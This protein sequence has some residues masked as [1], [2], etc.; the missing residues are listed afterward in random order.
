MPELPV[1]PENDPSAAPTPLVPPGRY[2]P[3]RTRMSPGVLRLLVGVVA[4]VVLAAV[5]WMA[6]GQQ[7]NDVRGRDVGYSVK[8]PEVVEITFDVAKPRDA[9]VVCTLEALNSS[10]AQVGS[11]EVTI[12]PSEVGEARFTTEIA[13]SEEAVT[14]VVESCRSV[15]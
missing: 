6:F 13:T 5:A 2:G 4:V 14:A 10:Y 9:T 12:G 8:S 7:G 15:Q 1:G 11:R 3:A